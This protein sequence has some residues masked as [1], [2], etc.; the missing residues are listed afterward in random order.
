MGELLT[1]QANVKNEFILHR[2]S[3]AEPEPKPGEPH[4]FEA[5]SNLFRLWSQIIFN[6]YRYVFYYSWC[7]EDAKMNRNYFFYY[8]CEIFVMA[9]IVQ[10]LC[11]KLRN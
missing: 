1:L 7:V 2:Y 11:Y 9:F 10:F 4:Y 8:H 5:V 6:K 3:A